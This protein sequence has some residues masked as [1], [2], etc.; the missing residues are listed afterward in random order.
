MNWRAGFDDLLAAM[1]PGIAYSTQQLCARVG[2]S[3]MTTRTLLRRAQL[4]GWLRRASGVKG[5][6]FWI[7]V[8]DAQDDC[9]KIAVDMEAARGNG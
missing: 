8:V 6:W 5:E 4:D 3:Y 1:T 9:Q 7:R 2:M